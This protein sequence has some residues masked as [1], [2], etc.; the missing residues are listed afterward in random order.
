MLAALPHEVHEELVQDALCTAAQ[1]IEAAEL[2][3]RKLYPSLVAA[4]ELDWAELVLEMNASACSGSL[5]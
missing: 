5:F 4:R 3:G 1:M 2:S